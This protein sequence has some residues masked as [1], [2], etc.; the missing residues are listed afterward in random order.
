MILGDR[1]CIWDLLS[2]SSCT[3]S[4]LYS[5]TEAFHSDLC[6]SH[7][8]PGTCGGISLIGCKTLCGQSPL[9]VQPYTT[10][11]PEY[12]ALHTIGNYWEPWCVLGSIKFIR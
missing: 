9:L 1:I 4:E 6:L 5:K 3:I 8:Q 11:T 7:V 10:Q 12:R 2:D